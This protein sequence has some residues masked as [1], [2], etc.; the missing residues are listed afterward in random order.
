MLK[1]I[2]QERLMLY[3]MIV[4]CFPLIF[5]FFHF[6]SRKGQIDQLKTRMNHVELQTLNRQKRQATNRLVKSHYKDADHFYIDKHLETLVFLEPEIE[7]LQK[8]MNQKNFPENE[9]MKK[10][11]ATLTGPENQFLFSEGMVQT[12]SDFQETTETLVHPV[13]INA[14]D[15]QKVLSRI[16]GVKIGN[17]VPPPQS[18]Q[19]IILDFKLDRKQGQNKSEVFLLNMK[20]L[21]REFVNS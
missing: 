4:C 10:R 20:I 21:K 5:V 7:A 12:F 13:E 15:L 17:S 16:E 11:L 19:L 6:Y 1:T 9:Q 18:P 3:L 2:P 14:T 8:V